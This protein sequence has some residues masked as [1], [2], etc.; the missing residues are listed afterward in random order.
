MNPTT[1]SS[2][3]EKGSLGV[4]VVT[5]SDTR[6]LETDRSGQILVDFV[7]AAGH[8]LIG[9]EILID[10][11]MLIR[12]HVERL[13]DDQ[14]VEVVLITGGT[15]ITH[16]DVTPDAIAPLITKEIPGFGELFRMLSYQEIGAA[17]IQSRAIAAL[18]KTTLVF[19]LPGSTGAVQL[20]VDKIIRPQL[21]IETRPCNFVQL[22]PRIAEE[23]G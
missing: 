15:G 12:K 22:L 9:R 18:C 21:D 3:G 11:E 13:C 6:T 14:T 23:K 7:T 5:V 19:A 10:D 8:H 1:S 20:A 4:S 17:T 2:F 16:R